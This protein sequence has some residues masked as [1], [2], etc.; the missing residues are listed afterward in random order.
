MASE[1][2][3]PGPI[4]DPHLTGDPAPMVTACGTADA[5]L[6]VWSKGVSPN[7]E[8]CRV[9]IAQTHA[10][11]T[12][13]ET[14]SLGESLPCG[15]RTLVCRADGSGVALVAG[16]Y[17]STKWTAWNI[18]VSGHIDGPAHTLTA[19]I[20]CGFPDTWLL[21]DND[22]VLGFQRCANDDG[23]QARIAMRRFP[24]SG[25]TEAAPVWLSEPSENGGWLVAAAKDDFGNLL[26][27]WNEGFDRD[28]Q[29]QPNYRILG[30][31]IDTDGQP[32]GS[33]FRIDA[34]DPP[35]AWDVAVR[36]LDEG[37]FSV[38]WTSQP[39]GGM[40]TRTV[41]LDPDVF[42]FLTTTTTTLPPSAQAPLFDQ[43]R[44][45]GQ[46]PIPDAPVFDSS[47]A[48][49]IGDGNGSL[50]LR[51]YRGAI[52]RQEFYYDD[53]VAST[54]LY[55]SPDAGQ[56]WSDAH[57]PGTLTRRREG[58]TWDG[59]ASNGTIL[60]ADFVWEEVQAEDWNGFEGRVKV[61][62]STDQGRTW[63]NSSLLGT[64]N[65]GDCDEF[66]FFSVT[67]AS[68]GQGKWMAASMSSNDYRSRLDISWSLDD[69]RTW[70]N[71]QQINLGS[72]SDECCSDE[73][74]VR[75]SVAAVASDGGWGLAWRSE[76]DGSVHVARAASVAA[77]WQI[78]TLDPPIA[79]PPGA[80]SDWYDRSGPYGRVALAATPT[81]AWIAAWEDE[82]PPA[83]YGID[84]EIFYARSTNNGQDWNAPQPLGAY[85]RVDGSSDGDP[86][87][88]V[89]S[90]GQVLAVWASHDSL[91]GTIG[92][93][94]DIVSSV[95]TDDGLT[96]SSPQPV[97]PGAAS[98]DRRDEGP[99][100]VSSSPGRWT[101]A[102][103]TMPLRNL[104]PWDVRNAR[105]KVAVAGSA[106]GD[107]DLDPGEE[108]DDAN[109]IDGCNT[110]CSLPGCNNE[111]VDEGEAC[112]SSADCTATCELAVCGDGVRDLWTEQCD[113]ANADDSDDCPASCLR[114]FCGDGFTG[115]WEE[116]DDA[117]S[118]DN[119]ACRNNCQAN[120]CGD[121]LVRPGVELCDDGD[122]W[123]GNACTDQCR[124][125]VCGDGRTWIGVEQCDDPDGSKLGGACTAD[126]KLT[127]V[128][129]DADANGIATVTDALTILRFAVGLGDPC[130]M[131]RCDLDG[132]GHIRAND[133]LMALSYATGLQIAL[134]CPNRDFATFIL[135]DSRTFGALMFEVDATSLGIAF[136]L[137]GSKPDCE[138][139]APDTLHTGFLP[140]P[141]SM[142]VAFISLKGLK[143]PHSLLRCKVYRR[144]DAPVNGSFKLTVEESSDKD[145][146]SISPPRIQMVM[147]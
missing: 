68:D 59:A 41:S 129:S 64:I 54:S 35:S 143:G 132:S 119:D 99:T 133:A 37:V 124:P 138:L 112:D 126:C 5:P 61:R 36:A 80:L 134:R 102:W 76:R 93:D 146:N 86:S 106:C 139:L 123:G 131:D 140:T 8:T 15:P 47:L 125:A 40:V 128:C 135:D 20:A 83:E 97:D 90:D 55:L 25:G 65:C 144:H 136:A 74:D 23:S 30:R 107:G 53:P 56:R 141:T 11:G 81:G 63:A 92:T 71:G 12:W 2:A 32:L 88:A 82:H 130:S 105:V 22:D 142:R 48:S 33:V 70:G 87:L 28:E 43:V 108:C 122:W 73:T 117:N 72:I 67:L 16:S 38:Q 113:D 50:L 104:W 109:D 44:E 110:N 114:G 19:G 116:C 98:D 95:S 31:A 60:A 78:T 1:A 49:L 46:S 79:P 24:A 137:S 111:V 66:R 42:T 127:S 17:D 39:E 85:A 120:F 45:V 51:R 18:D 14:T 84:S 21:A 89:S 115:W 10:D 145:G 26:A 103:T 6:V 91:G 58:T 121:D 3:Q 7:W 101:V 77:E 75:Y 118:T 13:T 94:G 57:D 96:W 52:D 4:T 62:R 100:V 147:E 69:G 29:G 34:F 9:Y 27:V